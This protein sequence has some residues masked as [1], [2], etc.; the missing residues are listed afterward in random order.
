MTSVTK[1]DYTNGGNTQ[2]GFFTW[3]RGSDTQFTTCL[4]P[5]TEGSYSYR[6]QALAEGGAVG[7]TQN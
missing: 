7:E 3:A 1:Y 2:N 4:I 5:E 6:V